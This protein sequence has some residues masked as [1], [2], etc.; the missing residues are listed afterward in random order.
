MCNGCRRR[1]MRYNADAGFFR[2]VRQLCQGRKE[3]HEVVG[4]ADNGTRLH[5]QFRLESFRPYH[6]CRTCVTVQKIVKKKL[7]NAVAKSLG[8]CAEQAYR[9]LYQRNQLWYF[10]ET[11]LIIHEISIKKLQKPGISVYPMLEPT[12]KYH[13]PV[14]GIPLGQSKSLSV[15]HVVRAR[16]ADRLIALDSTTSYLLE[17]T[18][19]CNRNQKVSFTMGTWGGS[20][21]G[22]EAAIP[23]LYTRNT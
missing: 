2:G 18:L 16:S 3:A 7:A 22:S 5:M 15:S 17:V 8:R 1:Q 20:P 23:N 19:Y 4:W 6:H 9:H 13:I 14:D 12:A 11:D 21:L 10:H